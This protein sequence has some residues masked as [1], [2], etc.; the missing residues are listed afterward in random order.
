MCRFER[1]NT[2]QNFATNY[3]LL[4]CYSFINQILQ[5]LQLCPV[6]PKKNK[7]E[8]INAIIERSP[9]LRVSPNLKCKAVISFRVEK[10]KKL[11]ESWKDRFRI[12]K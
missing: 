3:S 12:E 11:N 8:E 4:I 10:Y 7:K 9:K 2:G 1:T 5:Y 6:T